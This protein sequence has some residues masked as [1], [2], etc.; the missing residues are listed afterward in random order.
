MRLL[1]VWFFID[2]YVFVQKTCWYFFFLFHENFTFSHFYEFLRGSTVPK[3]SHNCSLSSAL[4]TSPLMACRENGRGKSAWKFERARKEIFWQLHRKT[5][6]KCIAMN[7]FFWQRW[8]GKS[9]VPFG[10]ITFICFFF[11]FVCML[12]CAAEEGC[13]LEEVADFMNFAWLPC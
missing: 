10:V 4:L 1:K 3:S 6:A 5:I 12:I 11:F 9:F 2:S 13:D 8:L 7:A